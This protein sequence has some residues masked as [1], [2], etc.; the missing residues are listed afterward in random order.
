MERSECYAD[1]VTAETC[2]ALQNA[3]RVLGAADILEAPPDWAEVPRGRDLFVP[4]WG[5]FD[6][7]EAWKACGKQIPSVAELRSYGYLAKYFPSVDDM[8]RMRL[9]KVLHSPHSLLARYVVQQRS[10]WCEAGRLN[11]LDEVEAYWLDFRVS[12]PSRALKE[13]PKRLLNRLARDRAVAEH[14]LIHFQ[15]L[16][17]Q[18]SALFNEARLL[19][20]DE[21]E[22]S[23]SFELSVLEDS[24]SI[25]R[26]AQELNNCAADYIRDVRQKRCALVVLRSQKKLLA[27]GEWDLHDQRWSQISEHSDE[28]VRSEWLYM[29]EQMEGEG[30]YP[31]K[32]VLLLPEVSDAKHFPEA[33]EDKVSIFSSGGESCLERMCNDTMFGL[34][35]CLGWS[36]M[37]G[38]VT[39]AEA[40]SALLLWTSVS[41]LSSECELNVHAV[42][43]ALLCCRADPD[44]MTDCGW[45]SL[46]FAVMGQQQSLVAQ[47]LEA[48]ADVDARSAQ[49]GRTALM[50][51]ASIGNMGLVCRLV[52]A[53]AALDSAARIDGRTALLLAVEA[54]A[55]GIAEFL[56]Q[57]EADVNAPRFDGK[58][59]VMLSVEANQMDLMKQLVHRRADLNAKADGGLTVISLAMET[60]R[61]PGLKEILQTLANGQCDLNVSC[62]GKHPASALALAASAGNMEVV[63]LLLQCRASV[64]GGDSRDI[65][66][67]PL[68]AASRSE[69]WA[70]VRRL[71]ELQADPNTGKSVLIQAV[72]SGEQDLVDFLCS[73]GASTNAMDEHMS[74]STAAAAANHPGV[75]KILA[76][77]R[78]DLDASPALG[79]PPL[80]V[81]AQAKRWAAFHQLVELRAHIEVRDSELR[82]A[83]I[84]AASHGNA[85][86]VSGLVEQRA[87]L[88]ARSKSG[89]TA[90]LA[91]AR[92]Q[93]WMV[94]RRLA[95]VRADLDAVETADAKPVILHL[96]ETSQWDTLIHFAR[97][98][99]NLEVR[100]QAGRTVLMYAAECGLDDVA[101][102]LLKCQADPNAED[103]K[104]ETALLKACNRELEGFM[105]ILWEGGAHIETAVKQSRIPAMS[106]LLRRWSGDDEDD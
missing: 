4:G 98:G 14:P 17:G 60:K 86:A 20:R 27:M 59:V 40:A 53:S 8:S 5:G 103:D 87:E 36:E 79:L 34:E 35:P 18:P 102:W 78:A 84:I 55:W 104:G 62:P 37:L 39:H 74:A 70:A 58:T 42:A 72:K 6:V 28:P 61:M 11:R 24:H 22:E 88:E 100:G 83:L 97:H 50:L 33:G 96:A 90:L 92:Q 19:S 23:A 2:G 71:V 44:V 57:A 47:L 46:M 12:N 9:L 43:R 91:A 76:A 67:G 52:T 94:V 31:V 82:T 54:G 13:E 7:A 16:S 15:H 25:V 93:S 26:A 85:K 80:L 101:W 89:Q 10:F 45:T 63:E 56:L 32:A 66:I 21:Q 106:K 77:A 73:N 68:D 30:L 95:E 38:E 41:P 105:R 81:A 49:S 3:K 64:H 51:A 65:C 69:K 48:A 75:L 1:E 99:S 29:Y